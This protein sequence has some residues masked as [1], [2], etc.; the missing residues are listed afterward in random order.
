MDPTTAKLAATAYKH[1][2]DGQ[3]F[4]TAVLETST[5]VDVSVDSQEL[6]GHVDDQFD[7]HA[8][9]GKAIVEG[10]KKV[11][12][13]I[14]DD[15][16]NV[17]D[18]ILED[19]AEVLVGAVENVA[20]NEIVQ[21][22]GEVVGDAVGV[23]HDALREGVKTGSEIV[24]GAARAMN[25]AGGVTSGGMPDIEGVEER[26]ER[27]AETM[28]TQAEGLADHA[29]EAF[30]RARENAPDVLS[31]V[32]PK[33]ALEE[34]TEEVGEAVVESLGGEVVEEVLEAAVGSIPIAGALI[35]S[36]Y[37]VHGG[38]K[39]AA[40]VSSLAAAGTMALVGGVYGIA[41]APFDGG[42]SWGKV[43]NASRGVSVWGASM[44]AEGGL[45]AAKGAMGFA[46][47]VAPGSQLATVP[48][49]VACKMGANSINK[50]RNSSREVDTQGDGDLE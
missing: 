39:A 28:E 17:D 46:D 6:V 45:I 43:A 21:N 5:G 41:A 15:G 18:G 26:A 8:E 19:S 37:L 22:V 24:H 2:K 47:Q 27:Y 31:A 48:A 13:R 29:A 20:N 30:D 38:A 25:K 11:S 14:A 1:R 10:F 32:D 50:M 9:G 49:K 36:Y 42:A 4:L 40:G 16:E 12:E 23:V 44:G 34:M 35:P 3:K 33:G 7:S